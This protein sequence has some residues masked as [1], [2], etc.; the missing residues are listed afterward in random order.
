MNRADF[1]KKL[2]LGALAVV[3]AP[4]V[5]AETPQKEKMIYPM[6]KDGITIDADLLPIKE[7]DVKEIVRLWKQTG[8]ILYAY[9][10]SGIRLID[11]NIR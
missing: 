2:G 3:V 11:L 1:F 9:P 7:Y 8:Q 5:F 6:L 4:K 10:P